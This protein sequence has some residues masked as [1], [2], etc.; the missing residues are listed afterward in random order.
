VKPVLALCLLLSSSILLSAQALH[1]TS[2]VKTEIEGPAIVLQGGCDRDGN[3][4]LRT[5]S[6]SG[7]EMPIQKLRADGA[8]TATFDPTAVFPYPDFR[9]RGYVPDGNGDLLVAGDVLRKDEEPSRF[10]YYLLRFSPTA[11]LKDTTKIEAPPHKFTLYHFAL[12]KTGEIL[13][14]GADVSGTAQTA[15]YDAGGKFLRPIVLDDSETKQIPGEVNFDVRNSVRQGAAVTGSDGNVYVLRSG[16]PA[17][18][19][20]ISA[21]GQI[22]HKLKI[23]LGD[24]ALTPVNLLATG[25]ALAIV[26]RNSGEGHRFR[27]TVIHEIDFQGHV[28][29]THDA[30]PG[31]PSSVSCYLA[32]GKFI[33]AETA[34]GS[35][36]S[37]PYL[38]MYRAE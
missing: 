3:L 9:I 7:L 34:R 12:F 24:P 25:H 19:Y 32:P 13:L 15:I 33:V 5:N 37:P 36:R 21:A 35:K 27:G 28:L 30:V 31:I 38:H 20:G 18:V 17:V 4:Y 26:S 8:L 1:R 16:N 29:A 2:D 10:E 11:E 14:A 23:D 22:L 6:R